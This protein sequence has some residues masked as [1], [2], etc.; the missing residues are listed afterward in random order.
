[1]K[2][3]PAILDERGQ[4]GIIEVN[5]DHHAFIWTARI[6]FDCPVVGT[7]SVI[8]QGVSTGLGGI[9]YI[10]RVARANNNPDKTWFVIVA[11]IAV[12]RECDALIDE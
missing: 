5:G 10:A 11:H 7:F 12:G 6:V 1:M 4:G 8:C 9:K 2:N 3:R